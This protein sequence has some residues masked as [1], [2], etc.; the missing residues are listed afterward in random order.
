MKLVKKLLITATALVLSTSTAFANDGML[1]IKGSDTLINVVQR[2]SEEYM[3][4]NPNAMIAVTGGGSGT[5]I[6]A[7]INNSTDIAN[8]SRGIKEKEI[9]QA[10]KNNVIPMAVVVAMDGIC[11]I[12]NKS[13]PIKKLTMDQIGKIFK[14]EITNWKEVGG[15][16]LAISLYGRQSNSGT[17][18][19]FREDVLKGEYAAS[20]KQMNG[21]SQIVEGIE[22]DKGAIGYVGL[23]YAE[24]NA[25]KIN[26]LLVSSDGKYYSNP[27]NS[28]DIISKAYP[29][30]RPLYQYVNGKPTGKVR[31]FIQFVLSKK[32]Q[33]IVAEEGFV[34]VPAEYR[35]SNSKVIDW[36]IGK[37]AC[38]TFAFKRMCCCKPPRKRTKTKKE[39]QYEK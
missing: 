3:K 20:M 17:F 30:V 36:F 2:L 19:Y 21:N 9:I 34:K 35:V 22:R 24:E 6:A 1:Q 26:T 5:G 28:K 39:G 16:D 8:S 11:V 29:I 15:A 10:N 27:L 12:T 38:N 31:E 25:K 23:G 14:G 37:I 4:I 7:L 32:G 33:A 13:N 18:S